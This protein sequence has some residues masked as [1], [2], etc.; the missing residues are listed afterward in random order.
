MWINDGWSKVLPPAS[1]REA[2]T[3]F[4]ATIAGE[5]PQGLNRWKKAKP[6]CLFIFQSICI[7]KLKTCSVLANMLDHELI[8]ELLRRTDRLWFQQSYSLAIFWALFVA[9]ITSWRPKWTFF[10]VKRFCP[11][12]N[13]HTIVFLTFYRKNTGFVRPNTVNDRKNTA[14]WPNTGKYGHLTKKKWPFGVPGCNDTLS[15]DAAYYCMFCLRSLILISKKS[16]IYSMVCW[17]CPTASSKVKNSCFCI[18]PG[19]T[20]SFFL[21][22]N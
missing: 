18:L 6:L 8:V 14:I 2:T 1:G 12:K 19:A 5:R 4:D 11:P 15:R 22:M 21:P 13:G 9:A 3:S 10:F 17:I 16:H 7:Q 20:P